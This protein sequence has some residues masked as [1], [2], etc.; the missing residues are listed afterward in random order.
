M[1][2]EMEITTSLFDELV[3]QT[4]QLRAMLDV[5]TFA[6]KNVNEDATELFIYACLEKT[7]KVQDLIAQMG[8]L[9][10]SKAGAVQ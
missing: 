3:V 9:K 4:E 10:T 2:G 8:G 6:S 1:N 7:E 5:G